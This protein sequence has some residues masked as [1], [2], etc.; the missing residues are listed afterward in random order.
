[1]SVVVNL[2]WSDDRRRRLVAAALAPDILIG[3]PH[4]T[5]FGLS[6][7][8]LLKDLAHRHWLMLGQ[9]LGLADA[10]FRAPDGGEVYAAICASALRRASLEIVAANDILSIRSSMATVGRTR[11]SSLHLLTIEGRDVAEVELVSTFVHRTEQGRNGSIARINIEAFDCSPPERASELAARAQ[12]VRR[13]ELGEAGFARDRQVP[14]RSFTFR[15]SQ[16][17]DF[18]GAGLFYFANYQAVIDRALEEWFGC[19]LTT[20]DRETYFLG[21]IDP[22]EEI[23]VQLLSEEGSAQVQVAIRRSDGKM[24]ARQIATIGKGEKPE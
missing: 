19:P 18:N 8:W 21:N 4:L 2:A 7:T 16:Q 15:P 14:R 6:E 9:L 13:G 5:P 10:D 20:L 22:H 3:M 12:Q 23:T 1:M 17:Q 11:L 24:I